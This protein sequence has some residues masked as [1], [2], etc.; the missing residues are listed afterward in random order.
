VQRWVGTNRPPLCGGLAH[1]LELTARNGAGL[2][3]L[4]VGLLWSDGDVTVKY[5]ATDDDKTLS[6][7]GLSK[8]KADA[9]IDV[10]DLLDVIAH[11]K[12]I[13]RSYKDAVK[14]L[15]ERVGI[16]KEVHTRVMEAVE[17]DER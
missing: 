1:L 6:P 4:G 5:L 17:S 14:E 11:L 13:P 3:L 16:S 10:E 7:E 15:M 12:G 2:A 9:I 8:A